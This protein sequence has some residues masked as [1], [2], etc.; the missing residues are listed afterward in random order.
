MIGSDELFMLD[1]S[2]RIEHLD[3][4]TR[5][6][7]PQMS[8]ASLRELDELRYRMEQTKAAANQQIVSGKPDPVEM[9]IK[10]IQDISFLDVILE[11]FKAQ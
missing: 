10:V 9:K 11:N 2:Q 6:S 5:S 1:R 4:E 7:Q 3:R 8:E